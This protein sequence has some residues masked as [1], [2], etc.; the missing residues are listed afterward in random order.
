MG[1]DGDAM[2]TRREGKELGFCCFG[3][4]LM[5][6]SPTRW[7]EFSWL[8]WLFILLNSTVISGYLEPVTL[9]VTSM[10]HASIAFIL[11]LSHLS[12]VGID[13]KSPTRYVLSSILKFRK[14]DSEGIVRVS[15]R[16]NT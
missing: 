16:S 3:F 7:T 11:R 6:E 10:W 4:G 12:D 9:S 15:V 1:N 5:L 2:V 14:L 8:L 13:S